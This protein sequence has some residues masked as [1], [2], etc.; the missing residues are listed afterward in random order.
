MQNRSR[1]LEDASLL[2]VVQGI[3]QLVLP[4]GTIYA[5]SDSHKGGI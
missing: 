2:A 5:H 1:M 4:N 3:M